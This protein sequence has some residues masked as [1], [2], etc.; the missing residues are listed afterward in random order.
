MRTF[1]VSDAHGYPELIQNA[2][3]HGGFQPGEDGFVYAGDLLDRGPDSQGCI[4]LVERY[5]TEVLL[6]NHE[7]AVLLDIIIYPSSEE[8][9][10][11]R[12]VLFEK[13]LDADPGSAWKAA[14]CVEGALITHAGV[15]SQY[16][17][18]FE[19]ECRGDPELLAGHL[20]QAASVAIRRGLE[21]GEW[22]ED[23][24]LG[25]Y[26]PTWFRPRPHTD[27]L[28]LAGLRQVV[29]H[30][31]PIPELEEMGFHMVDPCAWLGMEDHGRFRYAVIEDGEVRVEEGTLRR[32]RVGR[33]TGGDVSGAFEI[34][35]RSDLVGA[36]CS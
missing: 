27:L 36:G 25:D 13:V 18:V 29:G 35:R 10:A 2:L 21:T 28:P 5:A 24:I 23:G 15:S 8:T 31:W 19:D 33:R 9:V 12:R 11:C 30:T 6:G 1:V 22:D 17:R 34:D 16:E 26:G 3:D 4:D 14:T 7:L 20:N 32:P